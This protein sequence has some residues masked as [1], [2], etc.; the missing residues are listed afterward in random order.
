MRH[1]FFAGVNWQ[2]VYDKKVC[3]YMMLNNLAS[4]LGLLLSGSYVCFPL[5]LFMLLQTNNYSELGKLLT[6]FGFC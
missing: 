2:D 6:S 3:P 5:Q 1:S 4:V